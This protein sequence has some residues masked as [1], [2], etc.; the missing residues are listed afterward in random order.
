MGQGMAL[1]MVRG[2]HINLSD[3]HRQLNRQS[4]AKHRAL[5]A[6]LQSTSHAYTSQP[7]FQHP[8]KD[9]TTLIISR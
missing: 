7:S 2:E 1:N 8:S 5:R 6:P 3:S 9:Y 4:S